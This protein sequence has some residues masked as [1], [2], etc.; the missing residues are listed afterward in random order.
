MFFPGKGDVVIKDTENE[1]QIRIKDG[2]FPENG[3]FILKDSRI[4]VA[5]EEAPTPFVFVKTDETITIKVYE[6]EKFTGMAINI[7]LPK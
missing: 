7:E 6:S 3:E 1:F 2:N 5:D 4:Y